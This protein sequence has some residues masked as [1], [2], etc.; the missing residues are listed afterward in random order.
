LGKP[1]QAERL[2]SEA[3]A[4]LRRLA[5]HEAYGV[6]QMAKTYDRVIDPALEPVPAQAL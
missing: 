4:A 5:P 3:F 1:A 2:Y 6:L